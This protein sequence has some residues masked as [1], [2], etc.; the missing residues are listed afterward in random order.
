M[1]L[2]LFYIKP[3]ETLCEKTLRQL[4]TLRLN[5]ADDCPCDAS[6]HVTMPPH[7]WP[8]ACPATSARLPATSA[9]ATPPRLLVR[10]ALDHNILATSLFRDPVPLKF[11]ELPQ[12]DVEAAAPFN[13]HRTAAYR[14]DAA[15]LLA[16]G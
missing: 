13:L 10:S 3:L 1:I 5:S 8:P 7:T 6:R 15:N 14:K 11:L 16:K 9:R 4:R 12:R 2:L